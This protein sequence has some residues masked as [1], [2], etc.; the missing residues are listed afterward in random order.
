MGQMDF[1]GR[2]EVEN[3]THSGRWDADRK[4]HGLPCEEAY[5]AAYGAAQ[6]GGV[7]GEEWNGVN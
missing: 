6:K 1:S 5:D 2:A 4:V 3:A 7:W